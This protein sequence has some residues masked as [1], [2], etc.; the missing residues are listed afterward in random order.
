LVT[1]GLEI[2]LTS[3]N[4]PNSLKAVRRLHTKTANPWIVYPGGLNC[5]IGVGEPCSNGSV[6]KWT[7]A[8]SLQQPNNYLGTWCLFS[9][10]GRT[11]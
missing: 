10:V 7:S 4:S 3:F 2:V 9:L 5:L 8:D 6:R 1:L 11:C